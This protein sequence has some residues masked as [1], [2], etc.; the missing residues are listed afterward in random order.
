MNES[1]GNDLYQRA[2]RIAENV[3]DVTAENLAWLAKQMD[4]Y[5]SV[6]MQD[7]E[8]ALALLASGMGTLWENQR[9]TLADR[10]KTLILARPNLPGS[11]YETLRT[12]KERDISFAQFTHSCAPLPG[13]DHELEVQRFDFDR[14]SHAEIAGT[15]TSVAKEIRDAV[16][17]E[18]SRHYPGFD[19]GELDR[20]LRV[21]L[22]N[23]EDY[24][25]CS[26]ARR[27]AQ[28]LWLYLQTE[29]EEGIHLDVEETTVNRET[30][31]FFGVANPPQKD[32]LVQII[33][34]FNRLN[35]GVRR[36]YCLTISNGIHPYFLGSFYVRNRDSVT[37][38]RDSEL[39]AK[40]RMELYNTQI[41]S[42]A[43]ETYQKFVTRGLMSGEEGSLL[44]AF[45]AFCHTNLSHN[46]PERYGYEDVIRAFHNHSDITLKLVELF[47]VRFDPQI[48]ERDATYQKSLAETDCLISK[49]NTG[50]RFLDEFR[51][52][53]F[54]CCLTFIKYTLK[55]NFF[56]P[57]KHAL[58]FR[59][60]PSY[61]AE[62]GHEFTADLPPVIPFRVTFFFGRYGSGY[63]IGFSDIARGGWRTLIT[64]GRDDYVT[65]ANTMFREVFVLAH[66]QHFKNKDIYEGGSK[67]VMV[68]DAAN[69]EDKELV[70]QRLYK[71]QYGFANAFL[72]IF[73]TENGK[74]RDPR[75]VDY[76]GE[77]EP[78]ELGPDENMHDQMI[79]SIAR[80]SVKR[81]YLLGIGIMSSKK[82]GINH[83]EYG[84]TSTGV[85][86]FAEIVMQELGIDIRRDPYSVK[87]TGGPNGDVAGNALRL[88]LQRSPKVKIKLILDGTGA[89]F[90]P[91]GMDREEL[92][93]IVLREDL[94]AF[95]PARLHPGGFILYRSRQRN[96]GMLTLFKRVVATHEGLLEQWVTLDEFHREYANLIFSIPT[97]LFIPAGGRPE[98]IDQENY[99]RLLRE[100]GQPTTRAIVEGANSFI[101]PQARLE[102]QR[103]G[104]VIM[105][106]A[107]AN[108]CGVISS[109][110]EII[111]NLLLSEEEF[112]AKKA[113]YVADVIEILENRAEDEARLIFRRFRKS[114]GALT[115]TEISEALSHEINAHYA[116]LFDVF[117]KHPHLCS[118]PLFL[119]TMLSH[120]PHLI[121]EEPELRARVTRLPPKYQF[122][123]LAAEIASSLVYDGDGE[124]DV[125]ELLKGHLMRNL[126]RHGIN[127]DHVASA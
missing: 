84:V 110:Y 30:R 9:L 80:Q 118:E 81:G 73:V 36:A 33:E 10:E 67:L 91:E 60:D 70:N 57:S 16:A 121:R 71:L 77:D 111:A 108:K 64:K 11:L 27:V 44:N 52:S 104:V 50:H 65:C 123:I 92:S 90:D 53:I 79:E 115:Y 18:L 51:R 17:E 24:V 8:Q 28:I 102:L 15:E 74:A 38:T 55:T 49:Y 56:V 58:A 2:L 124:D 34:V 62:L 95:D 69:I 14:K 96:E 35:L 61:L 7:E 87:F 116:K 13:L 3:V 37:L 100:D 85:V 26:P 76:Y 105:R 31:V 113:R 94:D 126:S 97:D 41:L 93:R 20:L 12:L 1:T 47:R 42:T 78:I 72:D 4:P 120:L 89:V 63:H 107:S 23:N 6:T 29:R 19:H 88:I 127:I 119:E 109:S 48:K 43:S 117:K 32:F 39:F 101:T 46:Q 98:T 66:T 86:K 122:A 68:L 5:F 21:L 103:R 25:R 106:D 45:I 40:L 99:S 83:K 125:G 22:L 59:I 75:V 82:V 114:G 112:L 54:K